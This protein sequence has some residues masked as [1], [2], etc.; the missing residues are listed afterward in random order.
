MGSDAITGAGLKFLPHEKQVLSMLRATER[1]MLRRAAAVSEDAEA[2]GFGEQVVDAVMLGL[3][4]ALEAAATATADNATG[5]DSSSRLVHEL[6]MAFVTPELL[7]SLER[8]RLQHR[9]TAG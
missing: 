7:Q 9:A 8:E 2:S 4:G 3:Q 1:K 6:D 5:N